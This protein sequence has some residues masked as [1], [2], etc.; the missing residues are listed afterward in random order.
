VKA[1][2][3]AANEKLDAITRAAEVLGITRPELIALRNTWG[4]EATMERLSRIG[5]GMRQDT[6]LG[7]NSKTTFGFSGREAQA[8][9]DQRKQNPTWA[10]NAMIPGTPENIEYNRL[11]EQV[12]AAADRE[13]Q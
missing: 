5:L 13:G 12:A 2:G 8:Q 6:L 1:Q 10:K 9:I 3:A 11:L 7:G 4:A